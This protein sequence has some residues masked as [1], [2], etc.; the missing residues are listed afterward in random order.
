[1]WKSS[2]SGEF[3]YFG[4]ILGDGPAAEADDVSAA[5]VDGKH[6]AVAELV[7]D[8]LLALA[9][10]PTRASKFLVVRVATEMAQQAVPARRRVADAELA[11]DFAGQPAP[12]R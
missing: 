7:V 10:R 12:L 5:V 1:M 9:G 4:A 2:V 6:D 8:R 3:R 11:A